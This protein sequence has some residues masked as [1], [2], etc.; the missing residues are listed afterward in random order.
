MKQTI[1]KLRMRRGRL[2]SAP[3][4][5]RWWSFAILTSNLILLSHYLM[6]APVGSYAT[7]SVNILKP[8]GVL[9]TDFG[10]SE[11][12]LVVCGVLFFHALAGTRLASTPKA[13]F[14]AM[15][16]SHLAVYLFLSTAGSGLLAN[17]L[18][19]M[20]GRARPVLYDEWTWRGFSPF[21][22]TLF[23]SF[24]S[25]HATTI[26]ALSMA[27]ALV[28]PHCRLFLAVAA[29]WL[30]F[31]R[32]IVGAHYPSDVLAGLSLGAWF[33]VLLAVVFCRY[34][35]L[36]RQ[37]ADGWPVLRHPLPSLLRSSGDAT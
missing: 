20:I 4:W 37:E 35:L 8:V 1:E 24:P 9:I 5:P 7:H 19:R 31:T 27:A 32:V 18:K 26:G 36:F 30:G 10:K 22:G 28:A 23:E 6:D 12:I 29:L 34:G 16:V 15:L 3:L 14:E 2:S 17:F 11:W 33:S 21:S 25:G 13:R